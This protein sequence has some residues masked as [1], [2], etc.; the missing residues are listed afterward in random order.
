[1]LDKNRQFLAN[2]VGLDQ[3]APVPTSQ[4]EKSLWSDLGY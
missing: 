1:M 3:A 2:N 4:S